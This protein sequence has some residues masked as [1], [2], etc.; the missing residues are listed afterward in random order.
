LSRKYR[1]LN[2]S[3]LYGPPGPVTGIASH[4]ILW[5]WTVTQ[6]SAIFFAYGSEISD[7]NCIYLYPPKKH[8]PGDYGQVIVVLT[9]LGLS[10]LS[11]DD[12]TCHGSGQSNC[13]N[14]KI[15]E[16]HEKKFKHVERIPV[17]I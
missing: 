13:T 3:Q 15:I 5:K 12:E 17:R 4:F 9:P 14:K 16:Q 2:T 7:L 11:I 1:I 10:S 8:S 6:Q